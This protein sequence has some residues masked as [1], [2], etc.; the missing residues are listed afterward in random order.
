MDIEVPNI[1]LILFHDVNLIL[2]L[3]SHLDVYNSRDE[4]LRFLIS[5]KHLLEVDHLL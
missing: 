4:L 3:T 5:D 2:L 1:N